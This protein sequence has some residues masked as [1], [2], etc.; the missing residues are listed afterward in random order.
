MHD[1]TRFGMVA[2]SI[3]W[4]GKSLNLRDV[5]GQNWPYGLRPP[6]ARSL[7]FDDLPS[8]LVEEESR[9][10]AFTK[11]GSRVRSSGPVISGQRHAQIAPIRFP[12]P[13][14]PPMRLD[15]KRVHR[16][17]STSHEPSSAVYVVS[18]FGS[19][20]MGPARAMNVPSGPQTRFPDR[21]F[22]N[23]LSTVRHG[24]DR[25]GRLRVIRAAVGLLD[26]TSAL[27]LSQSVIEAILKADTARQN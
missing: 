27:C 16:R 14:G 10:P 26:A 9:C 5:R 20:V 11:N 3:K 25:H 19:S 8:P 7:G 2:K 13:N 12:G 15:R 4:F 21:M 6:W 17:S 23:A 18:G 22:D 1:I 24:P